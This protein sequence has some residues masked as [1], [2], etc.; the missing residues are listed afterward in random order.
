MSLYLVYGESDKDDNFVSSIF[1]ARDNCEARNK[2]ISLIRKSVI[3][4]KNL[5]LKTI[6]KSPDNI[7]LNDL[8]IESP[9]GLELINKISDPDKKVSVL[10]ECFGN[11]DK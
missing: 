7:S 4:N 6:H 10:Y 2:T 1:W 5:W 11:I 8:K 9:K 3:H